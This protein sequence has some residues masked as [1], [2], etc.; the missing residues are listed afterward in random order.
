MR[1]FIYIIMVVCAVPTFTHTSDR[2][3]KKK[4]DKGI[5]YKTYGAITSSVDVGL[6]HHIVTYTSVD[7]TTKR[8]TFYNSHTLGVAEGDRIEY[9]AFE[10][11]S[12]LQL[13]N[14]NQV[15]YQQQQAWEQAK[16]EREQSS[17]P[18]S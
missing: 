15:F 18:I 3:K 8:R 11:Q 7:I 12:K 2:P 10:S 14:P 9:A 5:T 1:K 17:C 4:P 6:N 13:E 16:R